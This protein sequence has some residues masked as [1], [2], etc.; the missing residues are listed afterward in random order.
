MENEKLTSEQINAMITQAV[1]NA[2]APILAGIEAYSKPPQEQ[3]PEP[4]KEDI[5]EGVKQFISKPGEQK[6]TPGQQK[7]TPG[8]QKPEPKEEPEKTDEISEATKQW[9][10]HKEEDKDTGKD[11]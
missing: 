5:S 2:V 3:K 10:Q 6:P 7:P 4:A 11:I 8:Q 9:L 1:N